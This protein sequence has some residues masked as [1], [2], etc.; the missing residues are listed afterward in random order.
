MKMKNTYLNS[1]CNEFA[2]TVNRTVIQ[3]NYKIDHR[4]ISLNRS[5]SK[6][7]LLKNHGNIDLK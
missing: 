5:E 7:N 2:F 4:T 1:I 3:K 6:H